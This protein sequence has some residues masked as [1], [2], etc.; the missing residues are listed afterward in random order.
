MLDPEGAVKMVEIRFHGQS[1]QRTMASAELTALAAIS[2]GKYAQTFSNVQP[3]RSEEAATAY[4][5]VSDTPI[6]TRK[7][8]QTPDVV[9]VLDGPLCGE[10]DF[11]SGIKR[12]GLVIMNTHKSVREV[13]KETG[14]KGR[15]G[16]A[17]ASRTALEI[18]CIPVGD[19]AI[20]DTLIIASR[21]LPAETLCQPSESCFNPCVDN[22]P[23]WH[24][25]Y[26]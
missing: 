21:V 8:K 22:S 13:R 12:N 3:E 23:A 9:V 5:R 19:N 20:L 17:D 10:V 1:E 6:R 25:A 16:V 15:L 14:I 24:C 4:V 7:K 11:T 26:E 18:N 2:Q